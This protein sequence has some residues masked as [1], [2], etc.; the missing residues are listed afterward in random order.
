MYTKIE[1]STTYRFL[2]KNFLLIGII[3][4]GVY[5]RYIRIQYLTIWSDEYHTIKI[6]ELPI[7]TILLAQYTDFNP[8]F[9]YLLIKIYTQI[10]GVIEPKMR[11]FSLFFATLSLILIYLI[12]IK[13]FPKNS[14]QVAVPCLLLFAF[15]PMLINYSIEIRSYALLQFLFLFGI[16]NYII[17]RSQQKPKILNA[18]TIFL[19]ISF[20]FYTHHFGFFIFLSIAIFFV[21]DIRKINRSH[22]ISL[23]LII[24]LSLLLYE[25]ILFV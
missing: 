15:H 6:I 23:S 12:T 14:K 9:Y 5:I 11:L 7:K 1:N 17:I 19:C 24:F 25:E 3:I 2:R 20:G 16:Y 10:T 4:L 18:L 13:L 21:I 22:I 8:P